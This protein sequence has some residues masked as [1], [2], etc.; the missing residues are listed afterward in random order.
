MGGIILALV[1]S[2][3]WASQEEVQFWNYSV[4]PWTNCSWS[5]LTNCCIRNL[6]LKGH[7]HHHSMNTIML[8]CHWSLAI[9][10][11]FLSILQENWT[12]KFRVILFKD[13]TVEHMIY[14]SFLREVLWDL[15]SLSAMHYGFC[16]M[17]LETIMGPWPRSSSW[18]G[19]RERRE[20]EKKKKK[21]K[22]ER[23]EKWIISHYWQKFPKTTKTIRDMMVRVLDLPVDLA[24]KRIYFNPSSTS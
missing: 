13:G 5:R 16:Q 1:E 3:L 8:F 18:E 14:V 24:L 19:Q 11:Y 21:E 15:C 10:S 4:R 9:I 20:L 17:Y 6:W 23:M 22:R 12:S 2:D 7:H